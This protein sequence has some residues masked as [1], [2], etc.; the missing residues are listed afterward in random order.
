MRQSPFVPEGWLP[1][2]W[3]GCWGYP[4]RR[5][6]WVTG[7]IQTGQEHCGSFTNC[8]SSGCPRLSSRLSST[9]VLACGPHLSRPYPT[10]L[11]GPAHSEWKSWLQ[12]G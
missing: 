1:L 5:L 9:Q 11:P 10:T 8:A 7:S 2:H 4:A 12:I 6:D 3:E